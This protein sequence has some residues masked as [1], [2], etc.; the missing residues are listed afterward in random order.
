MKKLNDLIAACKCGVY[1]RVNEH[2]DS[3]QT[4]EQYFKSNPILEEELED[5][6]NDV[7]E[8]M[9]ELDVMIYIHVYPDTPVGFYTVYHYD[10][11][12]AIDETLKLV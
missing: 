6:E 9:K 4:I 3:Y 7:Y 10:L 1:L 11:E 12:Q 8:K 5:I 2:R